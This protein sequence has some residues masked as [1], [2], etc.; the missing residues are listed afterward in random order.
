MAGKADAAR[1]TV[2][3]VRHKFFLSVIYLLN[4]L[5]SVCEE[6]CRLLLLLRVLCDILSLELCNIRKN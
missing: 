5:L 4:I 6:G 1:Q 2:V 3:N